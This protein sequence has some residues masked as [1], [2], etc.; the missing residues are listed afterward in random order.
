MNP[1]SS[2]LWR[3]AWRYLRAKNSTNAINIISWISSAGMAIGAFALIVV[4]S[5]FNGFESLVSSLY[6]SF[7]PDL[8]IRPAA[9]KFFEPD[10]KR[11][12]K[13]NR[14]PDILAWSRCLEENAYLQYEGK[15]FIATVKGVDTAYARVTSLDQFIVAG[16]W[17]PASTEPPMA[18]LGGNILLAL[19]INPERNLY[20]ITVTAARKNAR[21]AITPQD[22]FSRR[23]WYPSG[24]FAV[25]Q[26]FDTK[27]ILAPLPAVQDLLTEEGISSL[28]I[29][30]RPD[31]DPEAVRERLRQSFGNEYS[32]LTRF[33]QNEVLFR[34]MRLERWAVVAILSFTLLIISFNIMGSLTMLVID[35]KKDI[36]ILKA[37]GADPPM[38]RRLYLITGAFLG[39]SGSVIG[40][41]SGLILCLLQMK[42][43]FI[44]LAGAGNSFVIDAYPVV[45]RLSDFVLSLLIVSGISILASWL[46]AAR[47]SR[48]AMEF[49]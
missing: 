21:S 29:R 34:V 49:R 47:A 35:K 22:A 37:M 48:S 39:L 16:S 17:D 6:H 1:R 2:L 44:R 28:E 14:D 5:V 19:G 31:A 4:L 9:G 46:P 18:L 45:L 26:E 38:I 40:L 24:A 3:I 27:Y 23:E 36:S 12:L 32:I 41:L 15:D 42:F 7:Y 11:L 30:L 10:S 33:E 25:Q 43:G 8:I 20:P 13:L